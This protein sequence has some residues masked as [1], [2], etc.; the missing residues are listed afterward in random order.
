MLLFWILIFTTLGSF[1]SL[2]LVVWLLSIRNIAKKLS[3]SLTAFAAGALL[4]AAFLDL[5]PEAFET[6]ELKVILWAVLLGIVVFFLSERSLLW[7]H[8]HHGEEGMGV[9]GEKRPVVVLLMAGDALHNFLDGAVI[10]GSFLVSIPLGIVTSLAVFFHEI[11]HEIGVF[12]ALLHEDLSYRKAVIYN[13]LS[14]IAA[15]LG[16]VLSFFFLSRLTVIIPNVLAFAAGN[17]IYISAS[18][19]IPEIHKAFEKEKAVAQTAFFLLGIVV[20]WMTTTVLAE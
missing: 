19:L 14:G 11:P 15:L 7:F 3:L 5:L 17:F 18:D 4:A 16:A 1:V 8:H 12:G 6:G 2:F 13:V 20:I 10:G 9:K